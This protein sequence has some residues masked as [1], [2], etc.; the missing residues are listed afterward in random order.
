M[1]HLLLTCV[2]SLPPSLPPLSPTNCIISLAYLN[3]LPPSIPPLPY[4]PKVSRI[5]RESINA[6]KACFAD[7]MTK[8]DWRLVIKLKKTFRID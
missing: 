2:C 5:S 7:E 6:L 3:V 1:Y 4:P 8:D